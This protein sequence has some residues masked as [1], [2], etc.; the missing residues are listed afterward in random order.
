VSFVA[1]TQGRQV[2]APAAR[3]VGSA[4]VVLLAPGQ[5]A[6]STLGIVEAGNFGTSCQMTAVDGLRVYPP[7]RTTALYV[8]HSDTGCANSQDVT[9]TVRPLLAGTQAG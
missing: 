2:G 6:S 4:P 9:L 1:G 8:P 5:V 3:Q 7:N